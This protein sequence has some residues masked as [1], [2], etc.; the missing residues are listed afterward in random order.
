MRGPESYR[1]PQVTTRSTSRETSGKGSLQE[2]D[3]AGEYNLHENLLRSNG[4]RNIFL[5]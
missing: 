1:S 4:I 3:N 5:K 2:G